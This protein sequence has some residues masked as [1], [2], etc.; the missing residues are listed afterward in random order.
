MEALAKILA[1]F[2]GML[3]ASRLR[4]PLGWSLLGGGL[5]LRAWGRGGA[6]LLRDTAAACTAADLWLLVATIVLIVEFG[7]YLAEERN[8]AA[9]LGTV[10][11]WAGRHGRAAALVAIPAVIGLVPMPGGALF[12][13]PLVGRTV[14]EARWRPE[15]KAMVNYWFRHVWEYWWPLYPAVL[16]T[17][18][19]YDVAPW[20]FTLAAMPLTAFALGAGYLLLI[21]PHLGELAL[22]PDP[23]RADRRRA[24]RAL[25]PVV[26]V[27]ACAL[28]LPA[29]LRRV[30]PGLSPRLARTLA[31]LAGLLAGLVAIARDGRGER[32]RLFRA[33]FSRRNANMLLVVAGVMVFKHLLDASGLLPLA[34]RELAASGTPLPVVV[35]LLPFVAGLVTGLAI[36]FAAPA[37]PLIAGLLAAPGTTLSPLATIVLGY[38]CGYAGMM[39]SP[40]HLCLVLTQDFFASSYRRVFPALLRAAGLTLAMAVAWHLVLARLGW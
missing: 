25:A 31:M 27:V 17:L 19:I 22:P 6:G 8:A 9:L 39:L 34:S 37:F 28:A 32:R 1:V 5:A 7:R 12:S 3:L 33:T 20:R 18:S 23:G 26:L 36:G 14:T 29:P 35:A 15:W 13:A 24:L 2:A 10:R 30:L 40:V 16:V 11:G 38:A 4:V 21:R